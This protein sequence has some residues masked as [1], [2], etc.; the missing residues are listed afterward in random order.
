MA[1]MI[2]KEESDSGEREFELNHEALRRIREL[3]HLDET[4]IY[5]TLNRGGTVEDGRYRWTMIRQ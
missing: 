5:T 2:V 4:A 3:T 1:L